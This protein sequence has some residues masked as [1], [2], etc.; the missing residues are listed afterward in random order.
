MAKKIIIGNWKMNPLDI[1]EASLILSEIAR[2]RE[3]FKNINVVVCPP[4]LFIE[5]LSSLSKNR[6]I[7]GAQDFFFGDVG[8]Y[9]G[10]ISTKML[11]LSG[12]KYV[13]A[14]HSEKRAVGD[15]DI[16]INQKIRSSL[17]AGLKTVLCVGESVRD[18]SGDYLSFIKNQ[19]ISDLDKIKKEWLKNLI[20]AYEPMWAIGKNAIRSA[21][22]ADVLE[23]SIFI[24][25][26]LVELFGRDEGIKVPIIY[27]GSVDSNNCVNFLNQGK[28]DGL[29]VGRESLNPVNFIKI[30]KSVNE[31]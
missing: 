27:G 4:V 13:I 19:I 23:A 30:L 21:D 28:V 2:N 25:K 31:I 1:K 12:V 16:L 6:V 3:G 11:K 18:E 22:P 5:R 17:S 29:L 9:T 7:I 26:I 10:Q 15:S 24:K 8:S 20:I 14:G